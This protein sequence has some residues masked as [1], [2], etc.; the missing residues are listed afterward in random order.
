MMQ[1]TKK[2]HDTMYQKQYMM[3]KRKYQMSV[4][5][6]MFQEWYQQKYPRSN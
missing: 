6:K 5:R 2:A 1:R 3:P 4:Q